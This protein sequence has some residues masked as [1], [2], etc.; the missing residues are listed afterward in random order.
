MTAIDG[1]S[2]PKN[3]LIL[4][5]AW[6]E[7][8]KQ[9]YTKLEEANA[10]I[11]VTVSLYHSQPTGRVV[12][13]KDFSADGF[14]FYTNYESRK[15]QELQANPRACLLF[16]WFALQKQVRIEGEVVHVSREASIAY[17]ATRPRSSQLA[18]HASA[19]SSVIISREQL[20]DRY[21][22]SEEQFIG[23][24][25]PCPSNWGGYQLQPNYMEFWQGQEHRLHDRIAYANKNPGSDWTYQRLAP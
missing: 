5:T 2:L 17:F 24:T 11:L 4:F 3:P 21:L 9:T 23:K 8:A 16:H 1:Q 19:Q 20:M 12:L 6:Y 7:E 10:M 13:L 18:A 15:A 14:T 25:V 22:E